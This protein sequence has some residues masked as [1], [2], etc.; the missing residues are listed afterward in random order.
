MA[1]GTLLG[2]QVG[3]DVPA[4]ATLKVLQIE[5]KSVHSVSCVLVV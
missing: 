4:R 3:S 1:A 5:L 2:H